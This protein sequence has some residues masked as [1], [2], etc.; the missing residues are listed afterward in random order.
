M[1]L[2]EQPDEIGEKDEDTMA[3]ILNAN[4]ERTANL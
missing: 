3:G 1:G 4:G 2:S